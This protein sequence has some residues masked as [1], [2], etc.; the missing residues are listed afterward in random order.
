MPFAYP[1]SNWDCYLPLLAI[2]SFIFS[3]RIFNSLFVSVSTA[4]T[5]ISF[6]FFISTLGFFNSA[7]SC[8][9]VASSCFD[10]VISLSFSAK[11]LSCSA[12]RVA[13]SAS[14]SALAAFTFSSSS[15]NVNFFSIVTSD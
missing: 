8:S 13:I 11:I 2:I 10:C 12:L 3:A 4:P 5:V 15:A 6:S 14:F 9:L 7:I 1:L